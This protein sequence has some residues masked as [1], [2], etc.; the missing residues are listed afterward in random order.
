MDGI[1]NTVIFVDLVLRFVFTES[2][3][4]FV[5]NPFNIADMVVIILVYIL[6]FNEFL[7]F[8]SIPQMDIIGNVIPYLFGTRAFRI[9]RLILCFGE[10]KVLMLCFT[11][12]IREL[13]FLLM[14]VMAFVL[15]FGAILYAIADS[16]VFPNYFICA[17]YTLIT[18]TTVGYGDV[19]PHYIGEYILGAVIS[20]VG[21]VLIALPIAIISSNFFQYHTYFQIH[22]K[23]LIVSRQTTREND[24]KGYLK[25]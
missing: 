14:T 20:L 11:S 8:F 13:F 23:F 3:F 25:K 17:W 21:V 4:R 2:R 15:T 12:S 24:R 7:T 19:S 6:T 9:I 10:T 22:E 16:T 18:M 1:S 5:L